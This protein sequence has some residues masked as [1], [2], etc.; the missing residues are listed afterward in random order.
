MKKGKYETIQKKRSK[1]WP[2]LLTVGCLSLLLCGMYNKALLSSESNSPFTETLGEK[3]PHSIAI[4]GY[5]G[6]ELAADS[7]KQSIQ[8]SNPSQNSCYFQLTLCLEDG[9]QLWK[10][11]LVAPG[12]LS[13]R[14]VLNRELEKGTYSNAVLIYNCYAMDENRT[15]LNG[16][17]TKLTLWVK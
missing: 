7:K 17:E 14:V 4:P 9:T 3:N 10:S 6:I 5:E 1:L 16:A 2:W 8:F 11:A 12:K 13:D 15:P